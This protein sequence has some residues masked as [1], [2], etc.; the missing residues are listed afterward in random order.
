MK[1]A[2]VDGFKY[3]WPFPSKPTAWYRFK[4]R[5]TMSFVYLCSK[6]MFFGGNK[7]VVQNRDVLLRLLADK[8]RSL[9]TISN[10][11]SNIDDPFVWASFPL[12]NFFA[13]IDR[14]RYTPTAHNICF[15]KAFHTYIFSLGRC[16]P[17]VRGAGVFQECMDFC[18]EKLNEK[19]WVHMYPE[20]K[21][22]PE[23]IRF[24]WGIGRLLNETKEPPIILP[25]WVKGMD[26]VWPSSPPYYPLFGKTVEVIVGEPLD[27]KD[28][29]SSLKSITEIERRKEI[30]DYLQDTLF[31]LG[32]CKDLVNH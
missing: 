32:G 18:I 4:S 9:L 8:S 30:T 11:R 25:I 1:T 6:A 26:N 7:L 16:V 3:P 14:F 19:Q 5:M 20:G 22:T 31:E 23:P 2:N 15:T 10:H 27:S 17:I 12:S 21:V 13:N 29:L 24:K 28:I